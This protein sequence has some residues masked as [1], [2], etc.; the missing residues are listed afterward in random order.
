MLKAEAI[1]NSAFLINLSIDN[2]AAMWYAC[3]MKCD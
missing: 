1:L 3:N 2:K